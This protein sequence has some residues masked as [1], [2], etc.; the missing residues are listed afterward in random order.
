MAKALRTAPSPDPQQGQD[1]GPVEPGSFLR[2]PPIP[3]TVHMHNIQPTKCHHHL[4][5]HGKGSMSKWKLRLR[6][7]GGG[8]S[9]LPGRGRRVHL[10]PDGDR[11]GEESGH[12]IPVVGKK[13]PVLRILKIE[14]R[15]GCAVFDPGTDPA[16]YVQ[17]TNVTTPHRLT[18]L[19]GLVCKGGLSKGRGPYRTLAPG[20]NGARIPTPPGR[21][22]TLRRTEEPQRVGQLRSAGLSGGRI[23]MNKKTRGFTLVELTV[24]ILIAGIL[25]DL[26]VR[27]TA[28]VQDS[29]SVD[30]ARGAIVA[31]HA[32]ARAHA[33]ARGTMVQLVVDP[34][35]DRV[36]VYDGTDPIETV[37][38]RNTRGIDIVA[39]APIKLCMTP[40]GFA[41]TNCNSF[42][43]AVTVAL[44]RG[45]ATSEMKLRPMGQIVIL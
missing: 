29:L 23:T 16:V 15:L 31:L 39:D 42:T 4:I 18:P 26:A 9:P 1:Q 27:A 33:V 5:R 2:A 32:R 14:N 28:P 24:A 40:R 37:D 17:R 22:E 30:S 45:G 8:H 3:S 43:S 12:K 35:T 25:L 11:Q 36:S 19:P 38:L 20:T 41:D 21:D 7:R 13:Y 6:Q 34:T 44:N 10:Q